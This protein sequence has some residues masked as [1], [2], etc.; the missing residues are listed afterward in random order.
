M[1]SKKLQAVSLL[2]NNDK[3]NSTQYDMS[4]CQPMHFENDKKAMVLSIRIP[5]ALFQAVKNKA[6]SKGISYSRYIRMTLEA[7]INR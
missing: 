4:D 5:E 1:I 2:H 3:A 6:A 7:E